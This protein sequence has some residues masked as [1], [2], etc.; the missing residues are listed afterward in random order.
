MIP[1][2]SEHQKIA[3][4]FAH[5]NHYIIKTCSVKENSR[6]I[7]E[8]SRSER[9]PEQ[10]VRSGLRGTEEDQECLMRRIDKV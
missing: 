6:V 10:D 3:H 4:E 9:K 8:K 1:D 5:S 2:L 7:L